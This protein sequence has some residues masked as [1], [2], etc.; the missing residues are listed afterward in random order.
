MGTGG[1]DP[2][3][4]K[5]GRSETEMRKLLHRAFDLGI[6][7]FDTSPGY[8]DSELI[9]GRAL[10]SLPREKVVVSTKVALAGGHT[11]TVTIMKPR[12]VF[13]SVE[14]S[15]RRLQI[16]EID[17]VLI[18]VASPQYFD[19]VVN[20]LMPVLQK[21]SKQGK[22]RYIGSSEQTRSDGSHEWLQ[23]VLPTDI[24]DVAMVGHNMLNQ[25]ARR[26]VFPL[27]KERNIGVLNVFT[28]RNLFWNPKRLRQVIADLK[29][30]RVLAEDAMS[31]NNALGWL[32]EEGKV[33]SLVEAGYR[34]AAYTDS[35]STVMCGTLEVQELE[36][37]IQF[38]EKGPLPI[39]KIDRL[40]KTFG[41]ITEAIGN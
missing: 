27:C 28:V 19:P 11:D 14:S 35:V 10:R 25:S 36:E 5:S 6:N 7:L 2:L 38:L 13:E 17:I 23:R 21:L 37:D 18:S 41:H 4:Q 20:D 29:Q 1:H 9:L 3:G 34:F 24:I 31:D 39:D 30:R 15:L 8:M 26:L 40:Q 12:E 33:G 16:S 32:L 22:I